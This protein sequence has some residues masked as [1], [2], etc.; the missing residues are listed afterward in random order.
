MTRNTINARSET[1]RETEQRSHEEYTFEEPDYLGIPDEV[2]NRFA[3]EHMV[4]RWVRITIRGKDDVQNVGKRIQDGWVWVSPEEVPEM[5][6]NS[7]VKD[8]G[9]YSGVV[10]RG[11]LALA[12]MPAGKAEARKRFYENRS[13]EMMDA[14]NSQL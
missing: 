10:S 3:D 8:E 1:T 4:L 9:R 5:S 2:K 11:D 14:V 12:K 7:V 6:H 13:R